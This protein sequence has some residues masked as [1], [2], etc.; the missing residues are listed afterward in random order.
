MDKYQQ[1]GKLAEAYALI[2]EVINVR[3]AENQDHVDELQDIAN[4]I[5]DISDDIEGFEE[6]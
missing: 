6:E 5:A 4:T 1:I 3:D 2:Q